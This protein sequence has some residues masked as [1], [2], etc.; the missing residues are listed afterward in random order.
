MYSSDFTKTVKLSY[1]EIINTIG[2]IVDQPFEI[3]QLVLS[4]K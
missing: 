4:A 3:K 1:E 2:W